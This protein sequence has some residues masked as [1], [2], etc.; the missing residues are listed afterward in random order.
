MGGY[1]ATLTSAA[2]NDFVFGLINFRQF[3][4]QGEFG[5]LLGGY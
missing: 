2:E 5:P 4:Y 1:L 3:W